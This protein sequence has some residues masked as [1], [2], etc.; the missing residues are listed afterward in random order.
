MWDE[1][2]DGNTLG[3]FQIETTAG[4]RLTKE[5]KPRNLNDLA[6]VITLNRPGPQRSGLAAAYLRRR[7]GKE[8]VTI[9]DPRLTDTLA[10]T[11]GVIIYQEQVMT[12]CQVLAG[13]TLAEADDVRRMLGK[14]EV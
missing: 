6:D 4:T 5:F 9:V 12:V 10:P 14:K 11:Q 2:C 1:L 7:A 3:V 8:P 13:Y